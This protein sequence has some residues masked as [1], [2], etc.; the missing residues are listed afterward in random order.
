LANGFGYFG[1]SLI[2]L[3]RTG[4]CHDAGG[5]AGALANALHEG[6]NGFLGYCAGLH[7]VL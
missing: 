3:R 4:S 1:K 6:S 5:S 2:F 7:Y